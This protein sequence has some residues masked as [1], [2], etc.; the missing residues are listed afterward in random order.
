[1]RIEKVNNPPA[2]RD[3]V[4]RR[5]HYSVR[6]RWTSV[7]AG[8]FM[9]LWNGGNSAWWE[10]KKGKK[11]NCHCYTGASLNCFYQEMP[12]RSSQAQLNQEMANLSFNHSPLSAL[13][14]VAPEQYLQQ[15]K[16]NRMEV[17]RGKSI[18]HSRKKCN[19]LEWNCI[20][21]IKARTNTTGG[22]K[23]QV[24]SLYWKYMNYS[25]T[26]HENNGWETHFHK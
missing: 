10:W 15:L 13:S 1:M 26:P 20:A 8:L 12:A 6:W 21:S 19:T 23:R 11:G 22:Q 17:K 7:Q 4:Q 16:P 24:C 14:N 18:H 3:A 2:Q 9:M 5:Q 25:Q